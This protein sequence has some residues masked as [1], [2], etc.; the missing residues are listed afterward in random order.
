M[1]LV[2]EG[3]IAVLIECFYNNDG[4]WYYAGSY[5][6]FHLDIVSTKEW[7]QL[8]QE[9][10]HSLPI[11]AFSDRFIGHLCYHQGNFGWSEEHDP[12]EQL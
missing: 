9:V 4:T 6:A 12:S 11:R 8:S 7:E 2:F 5:K 3:L 10:V 1:L